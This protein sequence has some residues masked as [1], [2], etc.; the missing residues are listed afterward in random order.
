M[1]L[2][3][4]GY[5]LSG[6]STFGKKLAKLLNYTFVDT[7]K[8]IENL[9]KLSVEGIF[10]KYGEK[11]FRVLEKKII[12]DLKQMDN[13]VVST[14]GGFVCFND[15]MKWIKE[16]GVSIYLKL[17][18]EAIISRHKVAKRPRPLLQN[19]NDKELLEFI[20]QTLR[21]RE[22]YYQQSDFIFDAL[23][24]KPEEIIKIIL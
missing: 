4:V 17:T 22:F 10:N 20:R 12:E 14:G 1:R 7:D 2:F 11:V 8:Y 13:I 21:E 19:K 15:N 23:N 3:I 16:N 6:K 9:Y 5:M 24:L 18:P